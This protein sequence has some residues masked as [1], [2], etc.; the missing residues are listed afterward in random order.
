MFAHWHFQGWTVTE[1]RPPHTAA[2]IPGP[3]CFEATRPGAQTLRAA[4][5]EALKRKIRSASRAATASTRS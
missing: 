2:C 3:A 4:T 5:Y 1:I